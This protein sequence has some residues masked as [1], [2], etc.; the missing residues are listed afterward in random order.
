MTNEFVKFFWE[1]NTAILERIKIRGI[2]EVD[3]KV[4]SGISTNSIHATNISIDNNTVS[5]KT[6]YNKRYSGPFKGTDQYPCVLLD[7]N[8]KGKRHK[9]V[10]FELVDRSTN[11]E[12]CTLGIQYLKPIFQIT[13]SK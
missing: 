8:I 3:A 10:E 13:S 4:D 5:F 7:I 9:D 2:G 11:A 1:S 6:Q 12:K